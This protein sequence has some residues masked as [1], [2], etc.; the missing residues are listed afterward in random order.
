MQ[1]RVLVGRDVARINPGEDGEFALCEGGVY[2]SPS[3]FES[4]PL[5]LGKEISR[6]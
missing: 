4:K 5:A 6:S 1:A 2:P 3:E